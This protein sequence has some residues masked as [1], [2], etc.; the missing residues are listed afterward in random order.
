M[1]A[2]LAIEEGERAWAGSL[3]SGDASV[4]E[5]LLADDFVGVAPDGS[6]YDKTQAVAEVKA[7][8]GDYTSDRLERVTVRFFGDTAIA[9]GSEAWTRSDPL[10][11]AGRFVWT[12][13][14]LRRH[15][16]WRVVSAEDLIPPK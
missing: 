4:P 2:A 3:A 13:V 11:P 6:L 14:W 16:R 10:H 7:G 5:T 15:G 1:E 8:R 12:D 9:Q